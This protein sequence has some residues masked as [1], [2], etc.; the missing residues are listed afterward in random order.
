MTI[1]LTSGNDAYFGGS[2]NDSVLGGSG[3]DFMAGG[4]GNDT[5]DGGAD[6]DLLLGSLGNDE[7][8]G[9]SG[10]D[11]ASYSYAGSGV[12]ASI[13]F[14]YAKLSLLDADELY[15]IEYL[16]GSL[17]DDTLGGNGLANKLW[18]LDGNDRL[19]GLEG[20]DSLYGGNGDD[21]L[22][23]G[24][25]ADLLD[26]GAG[27]DAATYRYAT[28]GVQ[29]SLAAGVGFHGEA[30]GDRFVGIENVVGSL[31]NDDIAGDAGRNELDGGGGDDYL[32]GGSGRDI[33]RGSEGDDHLS[34]G[35]GDDAM[36]GGAGADHL[37]GGTGSDLASY[38]FSGAAVTI[39]LASGFANG[40]EA[41][42]DILDNIENLYGSNFDDLLAGDGY[43][44]TIYAGGGNDTVRGYASND[45]LVGENGN[46]VIEGGY[47]ADR[48]DGGNGNDTMHGG[49]SGDT[50]TGGEGRDV[51]AGGADGDTFV[52]WTSTES[53]STMATADRITDFQQTR[54]KV[55]LSQIDAMVHGSS[56]DTFL[57]IGSGAFT[58]SE[59]QLRTYLSAGSTYIAADLD[60]DGAADFQ[61]RFDGLID[62]ASADF[63]L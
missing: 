39:N 13:V 44:N 60:G 33:L 56:N 40:G 35:L 62:F 45:V 9:G 4:G 41:T 23:G 18:G 55:D 14:G 57:W 36:F 3:D 25:G 54:D 17:H 32:T 51:M 21:S 15:G 8:I 5:L 42:G 48:L 31:F 19:T 43:G 22:E 1:V 12:D 27:K 6:D 10:I 52:F 11:T 7:L 28:S 49:V 37:D 46:D 38:F 30:F 59:G 53:G 16:N 2:G 20:R 29:L 63:I 34:G 47:G 50:L 61:V 26:G 24:T 58:G